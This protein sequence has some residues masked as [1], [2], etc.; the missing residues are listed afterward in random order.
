MV[1][2]GGGLIAGGG[3]ALQQSVDEQRK[4]A[5]L[6]HQDDLAKQIEGGTMARWT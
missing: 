1:K 3:A 6:K 4:N 5:H 2:A